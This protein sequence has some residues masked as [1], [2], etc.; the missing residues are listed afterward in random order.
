MPAERLVAEEGKAWYL[1]H[2]GVYHAKKPD[3][4]RVV[5][6]CSARFRGT[7]LNDQLLQGPY[8]TNSLIGVLTRFREEQAAFMADVESMFYQVR[9]PQEHK[10]FLHFLW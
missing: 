3:S 7:S 4:I 1:P 6:D 5:F 9:V 2:H 8:F 10:I